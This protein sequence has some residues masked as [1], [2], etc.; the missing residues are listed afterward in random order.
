[1]RLFALGQGDIRR[2]V[3][4]EGLWPHKGGLVLKLKGVDSIHDAEAFLHCELQV[5]LAERALLEPGAAYI[6]DLIG[7]EVF[8]GERGIGTVSSVQLGAGEAPLLV[9]KDGSL[10]HL[11]PLAE[12]F[13]ES[14]S[15]GAGF[16]L[17]F[18]LD[19]GRKQIHMRLPEG[20][21]DMNAPVLP[22]E[23]RSQKKPR[24]REK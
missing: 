19:R 9:V 22:K 11:L 5:P 7:C 10:E 4:L 2:E 16:G 12:A 24:D 13:L 17:D 15:A 3:E 20:L 21:L 18:A 23:P 1:M 8:D 6:S 14:S